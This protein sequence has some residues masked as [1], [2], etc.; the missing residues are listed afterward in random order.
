MGAQSLNISLILPFIENYRHNSHLGDKVRKF[1]DN[2]QS[3]F[4][5]KTDLHTTTYSHFQDRVI[6][7]IHSNKKGLSHEKPSSILVSLSMQISNYDYI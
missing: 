5:G 3:L 2:I 7:R 6:G 4:T 1:N